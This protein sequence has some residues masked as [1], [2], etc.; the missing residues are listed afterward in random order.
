M[1]LLKLFTATLLMLGSFGMSAQADA[2]KDKVKAAFV[3]VSKVITCFPCT[4]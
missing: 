2:P 3:H 4:V 1:K